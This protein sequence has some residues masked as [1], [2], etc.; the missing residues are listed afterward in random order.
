[1]RV[2]PLCVL[3]VL[4][5]ACTKPDDLPALRDQAHATV[6]FYSDQLDQLYTRFGKL[7]ARGEQ[8]KVYY[9]GSDEAGM[10]A[11]AT[12]NQLEAMHA[13]LATAEQQMKVAT[14]SGELRARL[15]AYREIAED[16]TPETKEHPPL[17]GIPALGSALDTVDSWVT[18]TEAVKAAGS[19]MI[20]P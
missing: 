3:L 11:K 2:K 19:A 7:K 9:P 16:G 4:A 17:A 14:T 10:L 1:V 20:P 6:A 18:H 8:L 12:F 15:D 5:C 13:E